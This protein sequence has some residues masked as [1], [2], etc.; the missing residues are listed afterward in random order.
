MFAK[1]TMK[2]AVMFFAATAVSLFL[3]AKPVSALTTEVTPRNIPINIL[4]HGAQ[5]TIAGESEANNDL[6][7]RIQTEPRE[8]H[9]KFKGKAAGLFWMKMGDMSFEHVPA[10]YLLFTSKS[11]ES[12]LP[13]DERIKEGI[14]YESIK[15]HTVM[16][17]SAEG[18]DPERWIAEFIKFKKAEHL[19][20]IQEGSITRPGGVQDSKYQL[21]IKWPYQ[22]A[23]GTYNIEVLA[24]RDGKVVDR[25]ETSL[26][27]ERTGIVA[28]L[29]DLAFN[30]AAIYGIIAI[31]VAMFAG[32]AVGALFKKGGGAH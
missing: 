10:A 9:M 22:A 29:S 13:V 3:H 21:D 7:I 17:S 30:H 1:T 18:M 26:T 27:V 20:Q 25:A 2:T 23:P 4:Y 24:V 5:L 11:L 16:S 32:F 15:E 6:I 19:Y 14:G 28:K 12:L 31:V 8:A